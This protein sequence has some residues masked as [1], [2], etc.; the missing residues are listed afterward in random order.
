[1]FAER[2]KLWMDNEKFWKES[3][4]KKPEN[5]LWVPAQSSAQLESWACGVR[6]G[7]IWHDC[8]QVT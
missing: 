8:E 3:I 5:S 6:Q 7:P 1:M 4:R 2:Q